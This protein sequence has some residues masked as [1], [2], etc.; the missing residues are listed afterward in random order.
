MIA[1][2]KVLAPVMSWSGRSVRSTAFFASRPV[3][4]G[5]WQCWQAETTGWLRPNW[6]AYTPVVAYSLAAHSS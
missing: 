3:T 1:G 6:G 2:T 5:M 4:R